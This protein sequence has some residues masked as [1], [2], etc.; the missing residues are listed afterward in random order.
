ME[1]LHNK[2]I[3]VKEVDNVCSEASFF[4]LVYQRSHEEEN[5]AFFEFKIV[6]D[7][8][9]GIGGF[10][11]LKQIVSFFLLHRNFVCVL[12]FVD[13]IVFRYK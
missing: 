2:V 3:N 10:C 1:R 12:Y 5:V 9:N 11:V 8:F 6:S 13:V 7:F 4:L